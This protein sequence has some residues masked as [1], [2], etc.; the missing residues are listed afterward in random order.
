M[1][2][3]NWLA[4]EAN[5]LG[6]IEF[7]SV[8]IP[9]ARTPDLGV[10][11]KRQG[12]R[13]TANDYLQSAW[14]KN[15]GAIQNNTEKL[16]E[17]NVELVLED[18]YVPGYK[19]RNSSLRKWFGEVDA[20]WFDN[21]RRNLDRLESPY[22]FASAA[23][24][25]MGVGDY[26]FSFDE[27]TRELRQP[28]SQVFR[29]LRAAS[30]E[31]INNSQN[32]DCQNRSANEFLAESFVDCMFLRLPEPRS[33]ISAGER[34]NEEWLRGSDEF[35]P[36]FSEKLSGK[37]GAKAETRSQFLEML[38]ETLSIAS[39]IRRWAIAHTDQNVLTPQELVEAVGKLRRVEAV[40]TKDFSELTGRKAV[41]LT[42]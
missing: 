26:V 14:T 18:A 1:T 5:V 20:W 25:A 41:I 6:R 13:V 31:P 34:R 3:M 40:Y 33:D 39:H 10:M 16:S 17:A 27:T 28:L 36:S 22:L 24:L 38:Q 12:K 42:A 2:V 19:L 11:L 29:R 30:P 32:N 15:L 23:S 4:F 21:V 9:F 7:D 35:W 37:L 8:A